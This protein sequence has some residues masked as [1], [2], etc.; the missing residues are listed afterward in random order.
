MSDIILTERSNIVAI[1]NAVRNKIGSTNELNLGGI[2]DG[3]NS[4][5]TGVDTS[6]ATATAED[7]LVGETAYVNGN[8]I[9]GT[10]DIEEEI[11]AQENIITSQD[12]LIASIVSALEGKAVG[13]S[14]GVSIPELVTINFEV[15]V[16]GTQDDEYTVNIDYLGINENNEL[17]QMCASGNSGSFQTFTPQ[18]IQISTNLVGGFFGETPLIDQ[19]TGTNIWY[20]YEGD[21]AIAVASILSECDIAIDLA[22]GA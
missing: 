8:K 6:D 16:A 10:F 19:I 21:G 13:G 22:S 17:Q 9:T 5:S 15:T 3:I 18:L 2:V 12:T 1:A 11:T 14:S 4:I 20:R 7:I